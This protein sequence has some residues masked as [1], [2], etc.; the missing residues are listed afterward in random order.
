MAPISLSDAAMDMVMKMTAP[1]TPDD[2]VALVNAL[3]T[4]LRSEPQPPGD[5]AV[6]RHLRTLLSTGHYKR[7]DA[8]AVGGTA[9]GVARPTAGQSPL[10]NASPIRRARG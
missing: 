6:F 8:L 4:L 10:C 7:N 1:I 5:G 9:K 3:A 2:R